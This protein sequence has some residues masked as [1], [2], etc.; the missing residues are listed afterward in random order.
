MTDWPFWLMLA[1]AF[2]SA[3][4]LPFS[5]EVALVTALETRSA[6]RATLVVAATIDN[7]GGAWFNWW[8]GRHARR[9]EQRPWFPFAPATIATASQRF[10]RLGTWS[11]LFSWLPIIGDPLTFVAGLLRV[12]LLTFLPLV[13][14]AKGGR[15]LALAVA[16]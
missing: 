13:T 9:F 16:F 15:Y 11:L 14:I 3:T 2:A 12:P 4:L 10:Q 6:G 1:T 7:V 8:L 5:S